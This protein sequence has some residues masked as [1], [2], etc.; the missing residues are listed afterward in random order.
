MAVCELSIPYPVGAFREQI[1]A[2]SFNSSYLSNQAHPAIAAPKTQWRNVVLYG[3]HCAAQTPH[4]ED[5]MIAELLSLNDPT[6]RRFL[7]RAS[8]DAYHLP[9]YTH[10]AAN[11]E[12]GEPVAFYAE[13]NEHALLTPL[14]LREL[15]PQLGAP[16]T[17]RDAVSPYGYSGPV[18][19]DNAPSD[20]LRDAFDAF[21][22]L[23]RQREI[24]TAFIRMHPIRS[25]ST[26]LLEQVGTVV[27]HGAIVYVDLAKSADQWWEETRNDH[28][29]NIKRLR[30]LGYSIE[31]D[32][33][34][35]YPEFCAVYRI[36]MQ[37][38]SAHPYYYFSDS[39]FEEMKDRL[40]NRLH[41]CVVR[42]PDGDVASSGLFL[43]VD[44]IAEYHLGGTADAH[45]P[46]APSKLMFDFMRQW[47]KDR[48]ASYL[49][50]GGGIGGSADSLFWFKS[51]FSHS[52]ADFHT[53]RIVFD[54]ERYN[55]LTATS[56]AL[57]PADDASDQFFPA[58]R[59]LPNVD[60]S[61]TRS[62]A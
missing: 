54:D 41:L 8:H 25:V 53:V 49:N 23:A 57:R 19:T 15:P 62:P 14:I 39:Y 27:R 47:A 33:W 21:R 43:L 51:G 24:V 12:R 26:S 34:S 42:G 1:S 58:Y 3:Q 37:R 13:S 5:R 16:P 55:Q 35:A 18:A 52:Q 4:C 32:D 56:R 46:K 9:E 7:E 10:V 31:M 22:T 59:R 2:I 17:W 29:R 30:R 28:Q 20:F 45:F 44:G 6:W 61:A 60:E 36:T 38:L 48:G 11:Y 50:L 40:G